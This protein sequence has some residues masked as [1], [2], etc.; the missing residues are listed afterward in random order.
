MRVA[1]RRL[2]SDLRTFRPIIDRSWANGLS[3]ELRWLGGLLGAVRDPDVHLER[4]GAED[5]DLLPKLEP[6]L[7][8][9]RE[10]QA[11]GRDALLAGL[12]SERYVT[13]LDRLMDAVRDPLVSDGA[14]SPGRKAL[15]PLLERAWSRLEPQAVALKPDDPDERYHA[16]RIRAKRLRYAAEAIGPALGGRDVALARLAVA[17]ASLQDLLGAM[18]DAVLTRA[19]LE[20]LLRDTKDRDYAFTLGRLVER[21]AASIQDGRQRYPKAWRRV[22]RRWRKA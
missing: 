12:R 7:A 14:R 18:H 20:A 15:P 21:R 19:D 6:Y 4:L 2:R 9:L 1:T 11:A 22:A 3:D 8:L 16:V 17:A 10:R 5:A 13:L